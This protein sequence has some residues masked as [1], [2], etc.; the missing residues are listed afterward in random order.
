ME[1]VDD[2]DAERRGCAAETRGQRELDAEHGQSRVAERHRKIPHEAAPGRGRTW[3]QR[4][5]R[6]SNSDQIDR[7]P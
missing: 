5:Q 6:R 2:V 4:E 3:E 7:E 1:V